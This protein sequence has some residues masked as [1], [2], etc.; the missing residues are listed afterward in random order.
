MTGHD[1]RM[2]LEQAP[3]GGWQK[4]YMAQ[5]WFRHTTCN[6]RRH[7]TL[8]TNDMKSCQQHNI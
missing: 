5:D 7:M 6:T 3:G 1:D 2:P 4:L 8:N